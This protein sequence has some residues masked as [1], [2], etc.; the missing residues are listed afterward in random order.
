MAD[1]DAAENV[2]N[3]TP[4]TP[5]WFDIST[6]DSARTKEFYREMFGWQINSLDE[7]YALVSSDGGAPAGGIGQAGPDSPYRGFV[8]FFPVEDV[9]TALARAEKLG[10]TTAL[11]PTGTPDGRIA[12]FTDPDGNT[13]GLMSP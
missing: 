2:E 13:I 11:A 7:T 3:P 1:N 6:P 8:A 5:G 12:A 9:E 10:G 4:A